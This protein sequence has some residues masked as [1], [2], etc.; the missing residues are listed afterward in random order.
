MKNG[1]KTVFQKGFLLWKQASESSPASGEALLY[2]GT[3]DKL[4]DQTSAGVLTALATKQYAD[5]YEAVTGDYTPAA[6]GLKAWTLD[7]GFQTATVQPT[8]G[9][10]YW[11]RTICRTG[12]LTGVCIPI[13]STAHNITHAYAAVHDASGNQLA[14]S[15]DEVAGFGTPSD[16]EVRLPFSV[17]GVATPYVGFTVPTIIYVA[18]LFTGTTSPTCH[19]NNSQSG[20][21]Y[22]FG[23]FNGAVAAARRDICTAGQTTI[24]TTVNTG[25][26]TLAQV[27]HLLGVY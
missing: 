15:A 4:Y 24:P 8:I 22:R 19:A 2:A 3:D 26:A 27:V 23:S 11:A 17:S 12:T 5:N 13:T 25:T 21:Q 9:T 7:L 18:F 14:V 6:A 10:V 16:R 1:I 20:T